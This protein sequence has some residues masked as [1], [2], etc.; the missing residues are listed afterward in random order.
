MPT[1]LIK[2]TMLSLNATPLAVDKCFRDINTHRV[3][4]AQVQFQTSKVNVSHIAEFPYHIYVYKSVASFCLRYRSFL[5]FVFFHF[6]LA[7]V[8]PIS[9]S[10]SN[11]IASF[12]LDQQFSTFSS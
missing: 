2:D 6:L 3:H 10:T 5:V 7:A 12:S 1:T 4:L 9:P 11:L 8:M